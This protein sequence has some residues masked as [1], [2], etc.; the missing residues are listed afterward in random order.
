MRPSINAQLSHAGTELVEHKHIM[1]TSAQEAYNV[2]P[3]Q[4]Q[5]LVKS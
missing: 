4:L 2:I 5:L 1:I 3:D